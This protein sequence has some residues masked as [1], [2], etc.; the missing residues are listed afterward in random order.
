MLESSILV[1]AHPDDEALWF[2]SIL[3][4]VGE[5]L[6]CFLGSRNKPEWRAGRQRSIDAYPVGNISSLG[7]DQAGV[8]N[9]ADWQNPVVTRF[10]M[11]IT[12]RGPA[13]DLY[14][15][16]YHELKRVLA[17]R[18]AGYRN[19]ITHNP[20]GEYGHEEHVQLYQ[21]VKQLQRQ[22]QFDLWF[23]NCCSNRSYEFMLSHIAGFDSRY[24]TLPANSELG[25][26]AMQLYQQND[27][28][29]W[30]DD[31]AWFNEESFMKDD[32]IAV[33]EDRPGGGHIFPL[34]FIRMNLEGDSAERGRL[35]LRA[36]IRDKLRRIGEII[37]E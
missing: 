19:V 37:V 15:R 5:V 28:W 9:G 11:E 2:S 20:W 18:L 14:I 26:R 27:C 36:R 13:R 30:Y 33:D 34:N 24:L 22:Q 16:N 1:V 7:L 21:I 3:E 29:T 23:S 4:R 6:V 17:D 31:Y 8:F 10:G 25:A 35:P 32:W 12:R